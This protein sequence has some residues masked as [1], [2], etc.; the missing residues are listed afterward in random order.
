[1]E[2]PEPKTILLVDDHQP[3]RDSL[4]KIL[5]GEGFRVFPANDG[6]EAL[7]ILRKE[8]IQTLREPRMR[9]MLFLAP[10]GFSS[11]MTLPSGL[12]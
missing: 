1:M 11:S 8:F 4:A 9:A 10:L 6:E 7:D 3:F 5:G 2:I 12:E